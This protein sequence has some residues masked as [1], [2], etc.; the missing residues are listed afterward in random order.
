MGLYFLDPPR[1]LG[2]SLVLSV[3]VKAWCKLLSGR[4]RLIREDWELFRLLHCWV[5]IR[6]EN[7]I[8]TL[9]LYIAINTFSLLALLDP[10][11]TPP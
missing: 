10:R 5:G 11:T 2:M 7:P 3:A 6:N 1:G 4:I 8:T 9:W